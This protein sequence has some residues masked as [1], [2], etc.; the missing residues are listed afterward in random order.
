MC[1]LSDR[2]QIYHRDEILVENSFGMWVGIC[3]RPDHFNGEVSLEY[4]TLEPNR[5][6]RSHHHIKASALVLI[7]Q[8][9][10]YILDCD[11]NRYDARQGSLAYFPR[12]VRHGF[13]TENDVLTFVAVQSPPIKNIE[14]GEEDFVE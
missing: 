4:V 14:T 10:G 3:S 12:G 5:E 6:Y 2:I 7:L 9:S 11:G 1:C 8:G 13:V